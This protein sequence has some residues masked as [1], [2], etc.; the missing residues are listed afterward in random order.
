ML[1][2]LLGK[3][4]GRNKRIGVGK[5]DGP[6]SLSEA[7]TVDVKYNSVISASANKA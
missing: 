4:R 7:V 3:W 6:G 1:R 5:R 2:I